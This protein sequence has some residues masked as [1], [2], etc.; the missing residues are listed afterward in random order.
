MVKDLNISKRVKLIFKDSSKADL[1]KFNYDMVFT[2]P[3]YYKNNKVLEQYEDMPEYKDNEDW[4]DKFFYP[5]FSNA[6]KNMKVGG[7]FCINTNIE[8]YEMLKRFLG[9]CNKKININ[10]TVAHRFRIE[11][12]FKNYSKEFIYIWIK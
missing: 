4:Y 3:P 5:V 12:K 8:G 2:S 1:S 10:N 6:Y 11:G 9:K 7:H